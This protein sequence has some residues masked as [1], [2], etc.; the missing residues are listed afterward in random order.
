M[1]AEITY[2]GRA[3]ANEERER[4]EGRAL[5]P[6]V[7]VVKLCSGDLA[8]RRRVIVPCESPAIS[9]RLDRA[10]SNRSGK[11]RAEATVLS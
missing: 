1:S 5:S 2:A 7:V 3:E 9:R 11:C 6:A 8:F 4:E 10:T